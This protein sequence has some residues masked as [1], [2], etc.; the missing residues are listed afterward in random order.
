MRLKQALIASGL[1][2]ALAVPQL[3][4]SPTGVRA[5]AAM[6]QTLTDTSSSSD[7]LFQKTV[8]SISVHLAELPAS[9]LIAQ[10]LWWKFPGLARDTAEG[11]VIGT[12][13]TEGG[14]GIYRWDGVDWQ[15]MPGGAVRIG[16][17]YGNPYVVNDRNEIY[18]WNGYNWHKFPGRALDVGEGWV[19]GMNAVEGGYGIY[20]WNGLHWQQMPGGAVRIGG[21]YSN[22]YV[23]NDHNVIYYWSNNT[24]L[25][26]PGLASD[27]GDGWII[28]TNEVKGGY[29]IYR[30]SGSNWQRMPGGAVAIGGTSSNPYVVN[31]RRIIY[32]WY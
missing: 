2:L 16:G 20:R 22:P 27:V 26:L 28:G 10:K 14:Y 29:G 19:I 7:S 23:V 30:W 13:V 11:W 8:Q 24:W 32:Q 21:T 3:M 9:L 25:E 15:R 31:D 6:K 4:A 5:D 18:Q 1:T 17:T 12:N